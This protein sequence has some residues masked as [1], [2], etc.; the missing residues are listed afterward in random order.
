[1]DLLDFNNI[2][3]NILFTTSGSCVQNSNKGKLWTAFND[4]QM[5]EIQCL[6]TWVL[7]TFWYVSLPFPAKQQGQMIKL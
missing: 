7:L 5:S 2:A 3:I 1:M 4:V 6:C